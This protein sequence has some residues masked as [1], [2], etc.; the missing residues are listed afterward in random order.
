MLTPGTYQFIKILAPFLSDNNR[1]R[2]PVKCIRSLSQS[3]SRCG[4]DG[5]YSNSG[6]TL[7]IKASCEKQKRAGSQKMS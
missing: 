3:G 2:Q 1:K 6:S 4:H 5:I 7:A